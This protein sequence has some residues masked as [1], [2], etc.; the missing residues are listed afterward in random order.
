MLEVMIWS[1]FEFLLLNTNTHGV[2]LCC[3]LLFDLPIESITTLPKPKLLVI[4]LRCDDIPCAY[5]L[6][7]PASHRMQ[8]M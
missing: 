5:V 8:Y 3:S 4:V 7:P 1:V 2:G 6:G